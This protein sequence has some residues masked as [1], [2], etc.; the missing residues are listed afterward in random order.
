[1]AVYYYNKRFYIL[2]QVG[3]S[4]L[5][6]DSEPVIES[7][8]DVSE[9]EPALEYAFSVMPVK[10]LNMF[11]NLRNYVSPV[12]AKA[13]VRSV[14]EFESELKYCIIT[15]NG[16]YYLVQFYD[17]RKDRKGFE[18]KGKPIRIPITKP[19][20]AVAETVL[21]MVNNK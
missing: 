6:I 2:P 20:A 19:M 9:L 12:L 14:S 11:D 5:R 8:P 1:M 15:R 4:N 16:E 18:P 17:R 13:Q 7:S 3:G 10:S 21:S